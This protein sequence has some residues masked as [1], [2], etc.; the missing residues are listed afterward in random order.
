MMPPIAIVGMACRYAD[1]RSPEE[2]WENVLAQRR[3]FRRIPPERLR[4]EDYF[5]ADP[6]VPD[7]TYSFEAAL[8]EDY[9]F[10]RLKFRIAASTFRAADLSHWLALDVAAQALTDAGFRD[11]AS[12]PRRATGVF[13]GN[14]LTGEFSR[15]N[16][17][18][19]RWPYVRRVL[20]AELDAEGWTMERRRAFLRRLEDSYKSAFPPVGEETL[21]GALS[22]TIAGRICNYFDLKGGGYTVDGACASSLLAI[23][24]ACSRLGERDLDV[25][26]AGGVDLSLDPFEIVGFA[27][28]CALASAEMRVYDAHSNGFWPGEGCGTVVLM[29]AA[30]AA[31]QG[32]RIH[33]VIRGWG[34]SSDGSGGLTRP[35]MEGQ[36]LALERAYERAGCGIDSVGYFEGHGTGTSVGDATELRTLSHAR[37]RAG[38]SAPAAIGSVKANIGH[39]KAA[40]GVAGTIKAALALRNQVLPPTTGC[41]S[42]HPE[43]TGAAPA[44]A[45]LREGAAWPA[46]VPLRAG[47]SSMGFGGINVHIVLDGCKDARKAALAPAE[48]RLL[49]SA[50]DAELLIFSSRTPQDLRSNILRAGRAAARLSRA[51]LGDLACE[52]AHRAGQAGFRAAALAASPADLSH[53]L[54]ELA[55]RLALGEAAGIDVKAGLFFGSEEQRIGFL[56]PGQAAPVYCGR[57]ALARRFPSLWQQGAAAARECPGVGTVAPT[58]IAQPAIVGASVAALDLL[59]TLGV[60]ASVAAGHSVGELTGLYWAG[61]LDRDAVLRLAAERGRVM[62]AQV[63]RG[64]AMA[65]VAAPW[66]R[67]Q[68]L[69]AGLPAVLACFNGPADTVISGESGAIATAVARARAAGWTASALPVSHAFHSPLV[70][71]AAGQFSSALA[72]Y[73]FGRPVRRLL[74]TITGGALGPDADPRA[75]LVQQITSPVRFAE[76]VAC[77]GRDVG[78]WIEVGPG[79]MLSTLAAPLSAAPAVSVDAG[80]ESLNGFLRAMGAAFAAGAPID[81]GRFYADRFTRPFDLDR[82]RRFFSNPCEAA[83]APR[84]PEAVAAR[85]T[86]RG[87]TAHAAAV[88]R[89]PVDVL[90]EVVAQRLD[91]PAL[92]IDVESRFL[93]DLHLNSI[94]VAELVSESARR[95]GVA[96]PLAP[97]EY[98]DATLREAAEAL[99]QFIAQRPNAEQVRSIPGLGPWVRPFTVDLLPRRRPEAPPDSEPAGRWE[100]FASAGH[101]LREALEPRLNSLPGTGAVLCLPPGPGAGD[102]PLLLAAARAVLARAEPARLVVVQQDGGGAAFARSVRAEHPGVI[103]CVVDVPFHHPNAPEWICAEAAAARG[104]TEA[105]YDASGRR[106]EPFVR[107]LE[108]TRDA[109]AAPTPLGP[110]D[111]LVISGGG[112]GIACECGLGLARSTGVALGILGRS[113]PARDAELAA[114]LR[115]FS[116]AGVR[117]RYA[118]ADVTIEADVLNAV[119]SVEGELGPVTAILHGAGANEPKPL[120]LLDEEAF[121]RT[122]AP[123]V[124]GAEN[125]LAAVEPERLRLVIGFGSL[126]AR[127]GMP[128]EADYAVANE[129]LRLL[130]ERWR[131][132]YPHCRCLTIESSIWSGVGMGER[133]GRVD[134]LLRE[135]ITPIAP[136]AGVAH[137]CSLAAHPAAAGAVLLSGRFGDEP[138]IPFPDPEL[139]WSRFL[140]KS[141][142]HYPGIEL[143]AEAELSAGTDPYLADHVFEGAQLLPAVIGLEAMAQAA[144]ALSR[145]KGPAALE[146]VVFDRPVL[147][148]EG[149][150]CAI[151]VAALQREDGAI[152]VALRTQS[153]A[154]QV[155]HFR[156][157]YRTGSDT[158]APA[159]S[160]AEHMNPA[161]PAAGLDPQTDLYGSLLFQCG[162]FHRVRSYRHLRATE[163]IAELA[164]AGE[165]TWFSSYLPSGFVLG[166]PGVR[167]AAIHAIQACIPH[168]TVLPIGAR[169]IVLSS[170][171]YDGPRIVY[172]RERFQKEMLL[173]YDMEIRTPA[174]DLLESWQE[175]KLK[176][177]G[178]PKKPALWPLP[179]FACYLERSMRDFASHARLK[180]AAAKN[181]VAHGESTRDLFQMLAGNGRVQKRPGGKPCAE[182]GCGSSAS[183]AGALAL[184]VHGAGPVGCDI[185]PVAKR[186]RRIWQDLLGDGGFALAELI[187]AEIAEDFD[188][189]ATRV[190]CAAESLKKAGAP[191]GAAPRFIAAENGHWIRLACGSLGALTC[192]ERVAGFDGP[193]VAALAVTAE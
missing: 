44:L 94:A 6:G 38:A 56:F 191:P 157:V 26:I 175:L 100:L 87:G 95:L 171:D 126:I 179:L 166:D 156:A 86:V 140:E 11:G 154:F 75:L 40:A 121:Q 63:G 48:Q 181:G 84:E 52:L 165:E 137:V 62:A 147:V 117:F 103:A 97:T 104:Y 64:G 79:H 173:V 123:K 176:I 105:H 60:E 99:A 184:A 90:R 141:L 5:S 132:R 129:W 151:R 15:A 21:A 114:N 58:D 80:S 182:P 155:D 81:W 68:P 1:A 85:A 20:D 112:K 51:E 185:E 3:A 108:A 170:A 116:E 34:I 31:A 161:A 19:L 133:L 32:R 169:R 142:V 136:D 183:H 163:C 190:W 119:Q 178:A 134:A 120:R 41:V 109:D 53:G 39:T 98:A 30:D 36:L 125:L 186:A 46:G 131:A 47:V 4:E 67:V 71:G 24:N 42:P 148:P 162:R 49:S 43:L 76:A 96:P 16:V 9:E 29:R 187:A 61:A 188:A 192:V 106:Y 124:L 65:R 172:A 73:E 54:A 22:N 37:R 174:G 66:E 91:L 69:I 146:D 50:Q 122:F 168:R 111:V 78:L 17:M 160:L 77:G 152:D 18:R 2:L 193:L 7:R 138:A 70:A 128:G 35:D 113:D 153:T 144:A 83:P 59:R 14:T 167:D 23:A 189:A 101:P 130:L 139:P 107:Q 25:A 177:V 57:G 45:N 55:R 72:R 8:I 10:D 33:A 158:T 12:L 110:T 102:A 150:K 145:G 180:V 115:R 88:Q 92:A 118:A 27:K 93:T 149:P 82:P 159:R 164:P 135:G 13:I 143:I 89:R 74:S 127:T 28:T